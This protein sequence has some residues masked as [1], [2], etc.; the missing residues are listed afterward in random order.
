MVA[1]KLGSTTPSGFH[2]GSTPATARY[3]G[4][5]QIWSASG[6]P[7]GSLIATLGAATLSSTGTL[8]L[9]GALNKTLAAVTSNATGTLALSGALT[10]T[11]GAATLS[12][13]G[14][15]GVVAF[16]ALTQTLEA[17]TAMATGTLAINGTLSQT[18]GAATSSATGA[19]ALSGTLN[20][21]LGAAT[22]SAAGAG[23]SPGLQF[24][25]LVT[26]SVTNS[27][28]TGSLNLTSLTGGIGTTAIAGDIVLVAVS[29]GSASDENVSMSTSGYTEIADLHAHSSLD[30]NLGG[31]WK[32]MGGSP[33]TSAVYNALSGAGPASAIAYVYRG[34]NATTPIASTTTNTATNTGKPN[35]P[36]VTP[37]IPGSLVI[38]MV[39]SS[40]S[41]TI[42]PGG[43][44]TRESH[45]YALLTYRAN[46]GMAEYPWT[47]GSFDPAQWNGNA[48]TANSAA[49]ISFVLQPA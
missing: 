40:G 23:P 30:V 44:E 36:A 49:S 4:S 46:T 3:L 42:T 47:S 38:V 5:T 20:K 24:V 8:A 32:V 37:T 29:V 14:V 39:S 2:L 43:D 11:L 9:T 19:L 45:L 13:D 48:S 41:T 34:R 21:T 6:A 31:F 26:G 33:D 35:P 1:I 27:D 25:G 18:L 16:G 17:A 12:A 28:A 7:V 10:Q 22:L 15:L